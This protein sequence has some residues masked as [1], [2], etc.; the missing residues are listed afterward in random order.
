MP[1]LGS[2]PGQA[3]VQI[4]QT[5]DPQ[6]PGGEPRYEPQDVAADSVNQAA[7]ALQ[8]A[9]VQAAAHWG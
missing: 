7:A 2:A 8:A 4:R 9:A 1:D 3:D 6:R 5:A